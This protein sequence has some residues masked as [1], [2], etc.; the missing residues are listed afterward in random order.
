MSHDDWR[1]ALNPK[2]QGTWNLHEV[3]SKTNL[4][5]FVL[6]S[7]LSGMHGN[8]GQ[9]NYAAANTF[10]DSF[11]QFRHAN[12]L[13]ASVIDVGVI[14]DAGYVSETPSLLTQF[15]RWG[16]HTI[17]EPAF[18]DSLRL[19]IKRSTPAPGL[20]DDPRFVPS[21]QVVIGVGSTTLLSD[22]NNN[23]IWKSDARMSLYRNLE[24]ATDSAESTSNQD[25]K[26]FVDD[27]MARPSILSD[28]QSSIFL[29]TEIGKRI[30]EFMLKPEDE[31]DIKLSL[32]AIGV[33]SLISIEIRNWWKQ[34]MGFE[35]SVLEVLGCG[36]IE[37]L[38]RKAA[39]GLKIRAEK[40]AEK[41]A[42]SRI[43][44]RLIMKAP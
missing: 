3:L 10:L 1:G 20:K 34:S 19:A 39:E 24:N 23:I 37:E 28:E 12:G 38:G 30:F 4:Q 27:A 29:A 41:M 14:E 5:F 25:L 44:E 11:V 31:L 17:T 33:D 22:P 35:I 13:P 15:Q 9:A 32:T 21:G 2:V 6:I 40:T 36:S 26:R 18:L 43:D 8:W 16:T 42:K 7:S